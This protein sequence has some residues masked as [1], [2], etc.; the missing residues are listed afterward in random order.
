MEAKNETEKIILEYFEKNAS[1]SLKARVEQEKKT[2]AGALNYATEKAR[3]H[4]T[5]NFACV[6]DEVVFGWI[7][8]YFEDEPASKYEA[9]PSGAKVSAPKKA[10]KK[11][12]KKKPVTEKPVAEKP[13]ETPAVVQT[14]AQSLSK[15]EAA[16]RDAGQL[17]LFEGG[18]E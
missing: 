18:A 10:E 6:A 5:G 1:D 2:I 13:V 4:R 14:V 9:K 7:M 15:K 3:K 12:A 17:F 16:E 11:T 8:H